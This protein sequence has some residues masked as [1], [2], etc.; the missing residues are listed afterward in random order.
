MNIKQKI[1]QDKEI[2]NSI[3]P[4]NPMV[5]YDIK[6]I[7]KEIVDNGQ[8]FEIQKDYAKNLVICFARIFGRTIG[9]IANQPKEMAGCLDIKASRKGA[10]RH[11]YY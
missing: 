5:S 4:E 6:L 1:N 2:L 10:Y 9:I 8:F 11:G 3:V 7:I